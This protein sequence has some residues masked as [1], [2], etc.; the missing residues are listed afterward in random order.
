MSPAVLRTRNSSRQSEERVLLCGS[1]QS[2]S[3]RHVLVGKDRVPR[4]EIS[5]LDALYDLPECLFFFTVLND[6]DMTQDALAYFSV[7]I[8]GFDD[9]QR[10]SGLVWRRFNVNEHTDSMTISPAL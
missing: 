2:P 5:G 7:N 3:Q 10:F 4:V 8:S 9:L 1:I 6:A